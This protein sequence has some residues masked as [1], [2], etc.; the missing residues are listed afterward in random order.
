MTQYQKEGVL[1]DGTRVVLRPM[2]KEDR[3]K[4]LDFF[5][6][7][8]DQDLMFLR[9]DVRDPATIDDWVNHIDYRRVFPLLAEV[10]GRIVG[11]ATL[12]MRK[13]GWKRRLG[14]VRIVIARDYQGKGLGTLMVNEIIDLAAEFGLEKLIAEIHL[15]AHAA[16]STFKKAGF[17]A[18]AVFEDLVEDPSGQKGDLVVMMCNVLR[19]R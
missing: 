17:S 14:N 2:V 4:L 11:N 5:R 9:N 7:V 3:D 13:L 19:E 6:R 12:H 15:L 18:K 8:D 10:D 1:K 16:L